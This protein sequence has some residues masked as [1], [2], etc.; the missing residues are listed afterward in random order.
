MQDGKELESSQ[1]DT[2]SFHNTL[3]DV[4]P[5]TSLDL[6]RMQYFRALYRLEENLRSYLGATSPEMWKKA[7]AKKVSRSWTNILDLKE[8]FEFWKEST[9]TDDHSP[10]SEEFQLRKTYLKMTSFIAIARKQR[11]AF[12]H[13]EVF[14]PSALNRFTLAASKLELALLKSNET[15]PPLHPLL[16]SSERKNE[17]ST[18]LWLMSA[19]ERSLACTAPSRL[20]LSNVDRLIGRDKLITKLTRLILGKFK[21]SIFCWLLLHGPHGV[22]KTAVVR[23][24]SKQLAQH[25]PW[26]YSFQCNSK[27]SLIADVKRFLL[28]E[29]YAEEN[30]CTFEKVLQKTERSLFL[31]FE[32]VADPLSVL[33]RLPVGKHCVIFTSVSD[34]LWDSFKVIDESITTVEVDSLSTPESLLLMEQVFAECR[35]LPDFQMK[36]QGPV[37][38]GIAKICKDQLGNL[39]LAVRLF[40]F[41]AAYG[42]VAH[43]GM[44]TQSYALGEDRSV[45]DEKAASSVHVRGFYHTVRSSLLSLAKN[46]P[47][48]RLC[49]SFS[50][51]PVSCIQRWFLDL[52]GSGLKLTWQ[53]TEE[54]LSTLISSGLI[55]IVTPTP[56]CERKR[57]SVEQHVIVQAHVRSVM[58]TSEEN[59]LSATVQLLQSA[60]NEKLRTLRLSLPQRKPEMSKL[61]DDSDPLATPHL[62]TAEKD[63]SGEVEECIYLRDVI[64]SILAHWK[65][66]HLNISQVTRLMDSFAFLRTFLGAPMPLWSFL[67]NLSDYQSFYSKEELLLSSKAF[68]PV[69]TSFCCPEEVYSKAL[70]L[71]SV[72]KKRDLLD[73]KRL[74]QTAEILVVHARLDLLQQLF[75]HLRLTMEDLLQH[76]A[77]CGKSSSLLVILRAWLFVLGLN[78]TR[79]EQILHQVITLWLQYTSHDRDEWLEEANSICDCCRKLSQALSRAKQFRESLFWCEVTFRLS[80]ATKTQVGAAVYFARTLPIAFKCCLFLPSECCEDF[81]KWFACFDNFKSSRLFPTCLKMVKWQVCEASLAAGLYLSRNLSVKAGLFEELA[82]NIKPFLKKQAKELIKRLLQSSPIPLSSMLA[83][84]V[85]LGVQFNNIKSLNSLVMALF[86]IVRKKSNFQDFSL[87]FI[88]EVHK[89]YL[90]LSLSERCTLFR[91]LSSTTK[92][93]LDE[94]FSQEV[95]SSLLNDVSVISPQNMEKIQPELE[96]SI[97]TTQEVL[98]NFAEQFSNVLLPHANIIHPS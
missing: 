45:E 4:F 78:L 12:S 11:N 50:L 41:Q 16:I 48:S 28:G 96:N 1:A 10:S 86:L 3:P 21:V 85:T 44:Q 76:Y 77:T 39:P 27:E 53:Q 75:A 9:M 69:Y 59:V 35:K 83:V 80:K 71:L 63:P 13:G 67:P 24:L 5:L 82:K 43:P 94:T 15:A 57:L 62:K 20:L 32:D 73:D 23:A 88:T 54:A 93:V 25:F 37:K 36:I 2:H 19:Q 60:I 92:E 61:Q 56:E 51:L 8:L 89:H 47:V 34:I 55:T 26:Q 30:E 81:I 72:S 38:S 98:S 40:A 14:T 90:W 22:G 95:Q 18:K 91:L 58:A 84:C 87:Q 46:S 6:G 64:A 65:E 7:L 97:E 49:F 29:G 42:F 79:A 17:W 70:R 33:A 66:V 31:V 52:L 74:Q 68:P